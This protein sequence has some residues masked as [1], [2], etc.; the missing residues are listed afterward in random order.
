MKELSDAQRQ[1][2]LETLVS[3]A[4]NSSRHG[5]RRQL[6]V[7]AIACLNL[8]GGVPRSRSFDVAVRGS[9]GCFSFSRPRRSS[10]TVAPQIQKDDGPGLRFPSQQ[11]LVLF[12][13]SYRA[14]TLAS[15]EEPPPH[16]AAGRVA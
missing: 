9:E 16:W 12:T 6:R 11:A 7:G 1:R 5:D 3:I 2:V 10:V 14:M 8:G 13:L 4:Q 15:V